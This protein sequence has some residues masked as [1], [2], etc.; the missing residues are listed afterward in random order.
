MSSAAAFLA[1]VGAW[2]VVAQLA[3]PTHPIPRDV[4]E[5][6]GNLLRLQA[7]EDYNEGLIPDDL[8][9]TIFNPSRDAACIS[10]RSFSSTLGFLQLWDSA[11]HRMPPASFGDPDVAYDRGFDDHDTYAILRPGKHRDFFSNL[12]TFRLKPGTY[13]YEMMVFYN[14]C[15]DIIDLDREPQ[16]LNVEQHSM[17]F[18]GKFRITRAR[19]SHHE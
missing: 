16:E 14:T 7:H 17:F 12:L 11:G 4:A 9:I 13:K 18:G 1:V 2:I 6:K 3:P 19:I 5:K 10:T 8:R 15:R